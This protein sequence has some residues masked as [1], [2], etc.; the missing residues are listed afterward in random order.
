MEVTEEKIQAEEKSRRWS[1]DNPLSLGN[2]LKRKESPLNHKVWESILRAII[3]TAVAWLLALLGASH[4]PLGVWLIAL[5]AGS[6]WFQAVRTLLLESKFRIFWIVWLSLSLV[7][8]IFFKAEKWVWIVAVVFTFFFLLFRKYKPYRHLTSKRRAWL[9]LLAFVAFVLLTLFWHFSYPGLA[10]PIVGEAS[11]GGGRPGIGFFPSLGLNIAFYSVWSLRFFYI[12]SLIALFLGVRLHFMKIKSKLAVSALL[13]IMVP[14]ALLLIM[15]VVI[16]YSVLGESRAVRASGILHDWAA[17]AASDGGLTTVLSGETYRHEMR[18]GVPTGSGDP[19]SWLANFCADFEKNPASLQGI[20]PTGSG[21]YLWH[22]AELWLVTINGVPPDDFSLQATKVNSLMMN[23]LAGIVQSDVIITVSNPI[24]IETLTGVRTSPVEFK[25]AVGEELRGLHPAANT[26]SSATADPGTGGSIWKRRFYFGMTNLDVVRL[27]PGGFEKISV[28]LSLKSSVSDIINEVFSARN[29]LGI[30]FAVGIVTVAGLMLVFELFALVFG[31]RV[32]TGITSAVKSLHLGTKRIAEG[33]L[34]T[35]TLIPNEDELGDLA[36]AFNEMSSAVKKGREEAVAREN[37]E[38]ELRVAREIQERLL[39]HSMPYIPGF[40]ISGKSL[41]SQQVSGDYFDFLEM[42]SGLVGIAIADVSGKGIPAALLMANLQ[43]SLHGQAIET[44]E[45]SKV[46]GKI[47]DLL[48]RSTDAYMFATFFYGILDRVQSTFT[49]ANAGHNPPF[50]F[51]PDG[52]Y[53]RL[54]PGG[55]LIG[56]MA[57]QDYEQRTLSILPGDV[58]VLFTDGITEAVRPGAPT[59]ELKYFG[60]ERLVDVVRDV[61][62]GNI[63]EIQAA[64][65]GAVSSHMSGATPSDDITL[66]VIKRR[67]GEESPEL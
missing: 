14:V 65:L 6:A 4:S 10:R 37:L 66:V 25:P 40:E 7:F 28:L 41:P 21:F 45:A 48:A 35:K 11:G 60:E 61:L 31:L 47:N 64:I 19:P 50:L 54:N 26:E 56:F 62:S 63:G 16:L 29:P 15:E 13:L 23:R 49:Y 32:A 30:A 42:E 43:A 34:D 58:L 67:T 46:V 51:H 22:A 9:F 59:Q 2:L 12:F 55:P 18:S 53:E 17:V 36:A 1:G 39:P 52:S 33:D 8:V 38:R 20:V 57:R 3:A 44:G 5:V 27:G 24:N